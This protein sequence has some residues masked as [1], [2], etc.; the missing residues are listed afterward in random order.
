MGEILERIV[1]EL[2]Q[3][4][5]VASL[6]ERL[7]ASDLNSLLMEVFRLRAARVEPP[8]VL[9][10]YR[11]DRF[12]RPSFADPRVLTRLSALAFDCLPGGAEAIEL[13]PVAPMGCH[14]ALAPVDQNNVLTTTRSSEVLA[15]PTNL[16]ALECAL[17]RARRLADDPRDATPITLACSERVMRTQFGDAPGRTVHFR[18]FALVTAGRDRGGLD[19]ELEALR[20]Q[21]S[22]LLDLIDRLPE[23]GLPRLRPQ[24]RVSDFTSRLGERLQAEVHAPLRKAHPE[25][26]IEAFDERQRARGYYEA[27][28]FEIDVP[29]ADGSSWNLADGGFTDWTRKLLSN[30]KERLLIGGLGLER[31]A[32]LSGADR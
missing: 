31:L 19:F 16:M 26:S 28:A 4:G 24:V 18:L 5:L 21:L 17:R 2:G 29:G 1:R 9:A 32:L 12:T 15:D 14:A 25:A 7:S 23:I 8:Q 11:G 30:Q 3:P 10:R 20:L 13:S 27:I 22:I 6:A